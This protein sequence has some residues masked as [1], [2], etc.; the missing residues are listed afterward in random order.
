MPDADPLFFEV[1]ETAASPLLQI[2][3]DGLDAYNQAAAP[4]LSDVRALSVIAR[5]GAGGEV[6]GGAIGRTWGACCELLQLWVHE[7]HRRQGLG[8]LLL[9]RFEADARTRGCS[10]FYLTTLSF[11]APDFYRRHGY[12][13]AAEIAGYPDGIRKFWMQRT[14]TTPPTR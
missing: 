2:V 13:V 7:E 5:A 12:A 10:V 6:R 1:H 4:R 8:S 14:E 3:D 11:Q 9:R